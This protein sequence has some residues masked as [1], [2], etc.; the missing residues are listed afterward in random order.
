VFEW[1]LRV[2]L[3]ERAPRVPSVDRHG[4]AVSLLAARSGTITSAPAAAEL[5]RDG[6]RLWH[7][8]LRRVGDRVERTHTNRDYLGVI[9][10]VGP[11]RA[12]VDAA[13]LDYR[14]T[15]PWAVG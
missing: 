12:R 1:I 6:V 7:R 3:G 11:D 5:T 10:A 4:S 14:A 9:R 8:P 15:L 2:H 13:V